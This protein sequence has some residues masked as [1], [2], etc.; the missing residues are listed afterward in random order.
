[1]VSAPDSDRVM[2]VPDRFVL[3]E[4]K[5]VAVEDRAVHKLVEE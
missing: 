5:V 1:M 4:C 2:V 3:V